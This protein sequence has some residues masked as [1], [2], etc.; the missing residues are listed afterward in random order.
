MKTIAEI[1]DEYE[2]NLALLRQRRDEVKAQIKSERDLNL[3]IRLWHRVD[4]LEGMINDGVH[5]VRTM[6]GDIRG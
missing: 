4:M 5:A 2:C 3:R 6:R 1:V